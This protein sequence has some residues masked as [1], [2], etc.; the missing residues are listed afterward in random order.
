MSTA[1]GLIEHARSLIGLHEIPDGSNKVP[2]ITDWYPMVGP[3]CAMS[4]SKAAVLAGLGIKFAYCPTGVDLFRNGTYGS[5][6]GPSET[7]QVGDFVFYS[8]GGKRADH[9]EIVE[10]VPGGPK[11]TTLGGNVGNAYKRLARSLVGGGIIGFGR[12]RFDGAAATGPHPSPVGPGAPAFPLAR[13][14]YFGPRNGPA[15]SVSGYFSHRADL[16][17]WQTQ[18]AKRGWKIGTDGL[19]GDQ[20]AK[21][22]KAFQAEKGL[23]VDGN[24]GPVTWAAAWTLP[25]T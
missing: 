9:V 21:V 5:W 18:M 19:Y 2:G 1:D 4:A 6:H 3:W 11:I 20:T 23:D 8:F 13:G 25:T 17:R 14:S 12:P 24:I 15:S 16:S 7:P 22:A 10:V